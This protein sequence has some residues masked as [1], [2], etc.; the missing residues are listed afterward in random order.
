MK[1]G[2]IAR[3]VSR[4]ALYLAI[5]KFAALISTM[6]YI[7]LLARWLGPTKYGVFSLAFA[8][9]GLATALGGNAE[10]FLE[11]YTAEY[12]AHGRLRLLARAFRLALGRKTLLGVLVALLVAAVAPALA[13]HYR[14][15]ELTVLL[16]VLT[17]F[18]ASDGLATTGRA[19]L[20]G[21]QRFEWMSAISL[22]FNLGKTV[23]V[24]GLWYFQKGLVELAVG[25]TALTVLQAALVGA[26]AA[27]IV[28]LARRAAPEPSD[29]EEGAPLFRPMLRYCLPLLGAR[30]AFLSGQNLGKLVLARVLDA[31]TLGYYSFAFQTVERFVELVHTLPASLLP[32]LTQLVA[33]REQERLRHVFDQAFRLIQLTACVLSFMLFAFAHELTLWLGSPLFEPAVPILRVLA[34]VPMVR[35]AQQPLT[36]LFQA[37]RRP[38]FVLVLAVAKLAGE[39]AGYLLFLPVLGAMGAAV[40]NL[41]GAAVSYVGALWLMKHAMPEGTSGR[42][43]DVLRAATLLVPG[44]ALALL[45]D[46]MLAPSVALPLRV[47]LLVPGLVAIFALALVTRHDLEKLAG[48]PLRTAW[49]RRGRDAIVG[50][51]DQLARV[52]EP[53]RAA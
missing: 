25:L 1:R 26:A 10:V 45:F 42:M 5:E 9:V 43:G 48:L 19:V 51:L 38:G 50:R 28:V 16:P 21:L 34:L 18:I 17:L 13:E 7:A 30:A 12:Q 22:V 47:S 29:P 14:M 33:R 39:I 2:E 35:T 27:R 36:M 46:Q 24:A 15:P 44:L 37:L 20:Y 52:F 6:V 4:G 41:M 11:R 31:T 53:R 32:S 3:N 49:Q 23:L 8:I 40:A